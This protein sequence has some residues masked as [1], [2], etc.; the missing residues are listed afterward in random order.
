MP[1][2]SKARQLAQSLV[3]RSNLRTIG[4]VELLYAANND[5]FL[6]A[7]RGDKLGNYGFYWAAH[8]WALFHNTGIPTSL[9]VN[10]KPIEKPDWLYCR[11][12]KQQFLKLAG[13]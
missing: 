13:E 12:C 5:G 2:L 6:V 4:Q 3:C 9:G 1:S 7:T 11:A 8:L 10:V